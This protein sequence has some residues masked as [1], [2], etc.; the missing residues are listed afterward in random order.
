VYVLDS[1]EAVSFEL[2]KI[3]KTKGLV[4][5]TAKKEGCGVV[6][7]SHFLFTL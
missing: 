4:D 2:F 1:I 6:R 7:R 5:F 3:F